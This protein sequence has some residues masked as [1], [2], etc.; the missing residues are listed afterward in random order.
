MADL[1]G[2]LTEVVADPERAREMGLAGTR[3]AVEHFS[4]GSIGD[5]TMDVYEQVLGS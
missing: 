2:A 4:W 5:R 1:A 3:R